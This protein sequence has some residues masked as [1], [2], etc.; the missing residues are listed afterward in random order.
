MVAAPMNQA[1]F[2]AT[3]AQERAPDGLSDAL[4]VLWLDA[5]GD[6]ASAHDVAQEMEDRIGARL[7]AYLHRREGDLPNARYWYRRAGV[8]MPKTA[9]DVEWRSLVAELAG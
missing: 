3:L 1:E 9:L 5:R 7:H 4:R 2:E 6:W 8:T